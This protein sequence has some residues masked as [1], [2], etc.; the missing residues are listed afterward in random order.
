M[1][2]KNLIV[3]LILAVILLTGC[4][5][6]YNPA[7]G[8][9]EFIFIGTASEINLGKQISRQ[10]AFEK[11]IIKQG[12]QKRRIE[13]IGERIALYSDR[14]DLEYRFFL[15]RDKELNAF[16]V[17]GGF[18]YIHS[19]L[20]DLASDDELACVIGHE[21][22]HIAARHSVKRLQASLGY[23]LLITTALGGKNRATARQI[24]NMIFN[25]SALGYSR[26]DENLADKLGLRYAYLAGYDPQGMIS[27]FKKLKQE[28]IKKGGYLRIEIFSSHP[29]L[30]K[31]IKTCEEEIKRLQSLKE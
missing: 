10:I 22:T 26:Q 7:T 13:R 1:Q 27:F 5:T 31:R 29:D 2:R 11:Q 6:T 19:G 30:D 9:K 17:P 20:A 12:W 24:S 4:A 21:I 18:V 25:L 8:Q 16:A 23:Q 28:A 15:I 14:K 3:C